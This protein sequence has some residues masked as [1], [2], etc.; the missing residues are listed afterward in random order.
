MVRTATPIVL[1][2]FAGGASLTRLIGWTFAIGGLAGAAGA[3]GLSRVVGSPRRL[4]GL[5][6]GVIAIAAIAHA[7]LGTAGSAA[8]FVAAYAMAGL[9]QGAMVP[10][11]NTII[12]AA[13]PNERRGAAFGLAASVQALAF[14]VGALGLA[15]FGRFSLSAGFAALGVVMAGV[16]CAT[17]VGLREPAADDAVPEGALAKAAAGR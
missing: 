11:S 8:G 5:L 7:L 15:M 10:A 6:P 14:V 3:L 12:A 16:A 2:G 9:C 13:V 17:L 1:E 4:R